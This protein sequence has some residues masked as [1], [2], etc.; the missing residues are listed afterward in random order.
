MDIVIYSKKGKKNLVAE[1]D[2]G[3]NQHRRGGEKKFT[4]FEGLTVTTQYQ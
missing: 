2:N 4:K 1:V 3:D